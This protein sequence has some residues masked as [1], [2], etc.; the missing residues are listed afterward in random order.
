MMKEFFIRIICF[1]S[2]LAT[3]LS[4]VLLVIF[5]YDYLADKGQL[6]PQ[7]DLVEGLF[8]LTVALYIGSKALISSWENF[9]WRNREDT[10]V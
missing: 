6:I 3:L 2:S 1:S 7:K 5:S 8:I 10:K 9:F 4:S